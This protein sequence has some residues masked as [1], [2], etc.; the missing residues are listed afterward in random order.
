MDSL[1]AFLPRLRST[2][3][4]RGYLYDLARGPQVT[5]RRVVDTLKQT[6]CQTLGVV[7][8]CTSIQ[9]QLHE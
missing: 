2:G 8:P 7:S 9:S 4:L 1:V 6:Y 3:G 5:L